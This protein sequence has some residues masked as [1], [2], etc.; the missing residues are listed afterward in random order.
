MIVVLEGGDAAGKK[1][2]AAALVAGLQAVNIHAESYDFPHYQSTSGQV[3]GRILRGETIIAPAQL[4]EDE[5][6]DVRATMNP[7][8]TGAEGL[9]RSWC[10]DK[11]HIL[12]GMMTI[13]RFEKWRYLQSFHT[14][15]FVGGMPNQQRVLILDRYKLSADVYGQVDGLDPEWLDLIHAGLPTPNVT[16]ILDVSIEESKR[17]RPER[18]DYYER[19]FAKLERVRQLYR[20]EAANR[21]AR[22]GEGVFY[23]IDGEQDVDALSL[24]MLDTILKMLGR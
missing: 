5:I 2:Q 16:F 17:R 6:F 15:A 14:S 20:V 12:Q 3:I 4:V 18:R 7:A 13:D 22:G 11:A 23:V 8:S 24:S 9:K 10:M 19:D 21:N 1:T